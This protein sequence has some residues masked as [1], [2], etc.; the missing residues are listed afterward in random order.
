MARLHE[1]NAPRLAVCRTVAG[2][3]HMNTDVAR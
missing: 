1:R 3:E 2:A